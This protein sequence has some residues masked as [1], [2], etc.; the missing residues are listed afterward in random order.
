MES[1]FGAMAKS[2]G[3]DPNDVKVTAEAGIGRGFGER[4]YV[5][6]YNVVRTK[7]GKEL[8]KVINMISFEA[9]Y[10]KA[11]EELAE[12]FT[13]GRGDIGIILSGGEM[14]VFVNSNTQFKP[15]LRL[16]V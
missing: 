15:L 2:V 4:S 7:D 16:V 12:L 5:L 1:L 8:F 14:H 10:G 11:Q 3:Y 13:H 9:D 6:N